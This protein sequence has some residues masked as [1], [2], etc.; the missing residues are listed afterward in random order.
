MARMP[1][2]A[3]VLKGEIAR[4]ARKEVRAQTALLKKAI[5]AHRSE[6]AALK[7]RA[8]VAEQQLRQRAKSSPPVA[9]DAATDGSPVKL[10]FSAKRLAAHRKRLGL[11]VREFG[12]L[13]GTS[14]QTIYNWEEGKIRPQA[15]HLPAI[16]A[17]R[18]L[19]KKQA[20][21]HLESMLQAA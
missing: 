21:A 7:R 19:G 1:N 6:I 5:A 8:Q 11:S 18:G 10:R 3:T 13:F 2:I 14:A 4:I 15:K 9:A 12:L 20:R 17:L 16:A